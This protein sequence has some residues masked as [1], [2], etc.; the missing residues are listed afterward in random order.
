MYSVVFIVARSS[1]IAFFAQA[2]VLAV[3]FNDQ[4]GAGYVA[5]RRTECA[6]QRHDASDMNEVECVMRSCDV[7]GVIIL[8]RHSCGVRGDEQAAASLLVTT[9]SRVCVL[10]D[11]G[12]DHTIHKRKQ[13]HDG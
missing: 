2:T 3:A 11:N 4:W 8:I 10:N 7:C 6:C 5:C 13:V 9:A 1:A 12:S